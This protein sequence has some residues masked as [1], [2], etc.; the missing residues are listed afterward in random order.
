VALHFSWKQ[1]WPAVRELLPVIE[2]GLAPFDARPHWGKLFTVA[3]RQLQS[4]FEKL[5]DFRQLL[6]HYDPD[7]K[8]RNAFLDTHIF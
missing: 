7:G 6:V 3:P 8:F 5:T 2:A 4:S 1:N